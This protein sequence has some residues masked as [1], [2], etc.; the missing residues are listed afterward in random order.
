MKIIDEKALK[1]FYRQQGATEEAVNAV[2]LKKVEDLILS[3]GSMEEAIDTIC[4]TYPQLDKEWLK[5]TVE[6]AKQEVDAQ[7]EANSNP[8]SEDIVDLDEDDLEAV[9]GG[10]VGSWFKKNW[11]ILV[12]A[13]AGMALAA[14]GM[15]MY[16]KFKG[17]AAAA[18][19]TGTASQAAAGQEVEMAAQGEG[20]SKANAKAAGGGGMGMGSSLGLF[21]AS[22]ILP[23]LIQEL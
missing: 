17:G 4:E 6:D 8:D 20:A 16:S 21:A 11:P 18:K 1:D 12:G 2:D 5:K 9:A 19:G 23:S 14:G 22:T 13:A 15:A 3:C 10:S 7:L